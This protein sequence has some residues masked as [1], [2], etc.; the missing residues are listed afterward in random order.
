VCIAIPK[1]VIRIEKGENK[2][3]V[4]DNDNE[5][6][7]NISLIDSL[8]EGDYVI[9]QSGYATQAMDEKDA[10]ESLALWKSF[11]QEEK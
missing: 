1:K 6:E 9:V 3:T 4:L 5:L 10:E 2:A 11:N 7:V 8:E